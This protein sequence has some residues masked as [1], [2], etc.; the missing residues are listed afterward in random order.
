MLKGQILDLQYELVNQ[1]EKNEKLKIDIDEISEAKNK[2]SN[3]IKEKEDEIDKLITDAVILKHE[4][5]EKE[6]LKNSLIKAKAIN[7]KL[8]PC[9]SE[10]EEEIHALKIENRYLLKTKKEMIDSVR[11]VVFYSTNLENQLD[12][13]NKTAS[14][15]HDKVDENFSL[16]KKG[17]SIIGCTGRGH[18]D[19]KKKTHRK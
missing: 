6:S 3:I 4:L 7:N 11:K 17:C 10:F 1:I 5:K 16:K 18:I 13:T 2:Q 8:K 19:G 12:Q 14:D 15:S 9:I